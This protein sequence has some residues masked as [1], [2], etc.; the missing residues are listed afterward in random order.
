MGKTNFSTFFNHHTSTTAKSPIL[1]CFHHIRVANTQVVLRP[2]GF[3]TAFLGTKRSRLPRHEG[4][5][6]K[7]RCKPMSSKNI[8]V[9]MFSHSTLV[10]C[11]SIYGGHIDI[12]PALHHVI[13][14]II[15]IL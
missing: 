14:V 10:F 5:D 8:K 1:C 9:K 13:I 12:L 6:Y 2:Y 3:V 4:P 7:V 15:S 11:M